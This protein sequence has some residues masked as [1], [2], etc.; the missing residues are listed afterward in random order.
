MS[1]DLAKLAELANRI[2]SALDWFPI[3][4]EAELGEAEKRASYYLCVAHA[5]VEDVMHLL[6][7]RRAARYAAVATSAKEKP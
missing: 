4:D 5:W 1:D 2:E 6:A 7:Q 3:C